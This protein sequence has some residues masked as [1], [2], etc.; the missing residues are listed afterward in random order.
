MLKS[1][2]VVN[3]IVFRKMNSHFELKGV[4]YFAKEWKYKCGLYVLNSD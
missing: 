3:N 2:N 4:L 1:K